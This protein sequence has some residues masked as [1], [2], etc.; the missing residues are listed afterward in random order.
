MPEK[1]ISLTGKTLI[2]LS[3]IALFGAVMVWATE[4]RQDI[5]INKTKVFTLRDN[6]SKIIEKLDTMST[7]M[8]KMETQIEFIY[9][10]IKG[11]R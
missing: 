1:I 4:M 5:S 10:G 9:D 8:S 3:S 2:P 7:K 6:Q 11:R